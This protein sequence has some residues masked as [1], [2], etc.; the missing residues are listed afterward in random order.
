MPLKLTILDSSERLVVLRDQIEHAYAL[1]VERI[2]SLLPVDR[3]DV[4][5][6]AGAR[7]IPEFGLT[8][9][10]PDAH[11]AFLTV[12][13]SS[14]N[15]LPDFQ[16]NFLAILGHELHHCMRHR[17]PGYGNTLREALVSEGLACLFETELRAGKPPFYCTSVSKEHLG[18]LIARMSGEL[19]SSPYDHSGWF[20][21]SIDRKIPRHAG[22]CVGFEAVARYAGAKGKSAAQLW[23]VES[24]AIALLA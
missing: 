11:T 23:G 5:V 7:V 19:D 2:T 14:P 10:S 1:S 18:T 16:A 20:F 6:Q 9:Y 17:G 13:P 22:Y 15:L 3:V 24:N 21:G 4:V 12:N 8:G